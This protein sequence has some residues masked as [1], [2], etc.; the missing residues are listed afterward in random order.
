MG[1]IRGRGSRGVEVVGPS[2][3]CG[4]VFLDQNRLLAG[5]EIEEFSTREQKDG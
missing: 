4:P 1:A 3:E 2:K 5:V